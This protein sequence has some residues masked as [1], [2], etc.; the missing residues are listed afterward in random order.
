MG[1]QI[2]HIIIYLKQMFGG[3]KVSKKCFYKKMQVMLSSIWAQ[4][5]VD[6]NTTMG[7]M[8]FVIHI[9]IYKISIS[10]HQII[11]SYLNQWLILG[12][13]VLFADTLGCHHHNS[14]LRKHW[15]EKRWGKSERQSFERRRHLEV[16]M[17]MSYIPHSRRTTFFLH[18][19][20]MRCFLITFYGHTAS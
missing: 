5:K 4:S 8:K 12:D 2:H 10:V 14:S 19:L 11:F 3:Q 1:K 18:F 9:C 7:R 15:K 13:L 16:S 17:D 20:S 6:L